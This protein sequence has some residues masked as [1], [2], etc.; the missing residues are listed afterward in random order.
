MFHLSSQLHDVI[1]PCGLISFCYNEFFL[2]SENPFAVVEL[3]W[4]FPP[5]HLWKSSIKK[6]LNKCNHILIQNHSQQSILI[7]IL[8]NACKNKRRFMKLFKLLDRKN[9]SVGCKTHICICKF[10]Y[11]LTLPSAF[12][13]LY[14]LDCYLGIK[15]TFYLVNHVYSL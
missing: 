12:E 2:L 9:R 15:T 1:V 11:Q 7:K 3:T 5:H 4:K 8:S 10:C 13:I 6:N 14:S